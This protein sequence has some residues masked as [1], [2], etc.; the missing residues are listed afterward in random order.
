MTNTMQHIVVVAQMD[1]VADRSNEAF[2]CRW[3]R[4]IGFLKLHYVLS[5]RAAMP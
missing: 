5:K 1:I 3:E 4:V 2:A